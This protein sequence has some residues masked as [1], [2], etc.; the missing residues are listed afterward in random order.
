MDFLA[1]FGGIGLLFLVIGLICLMMLVRQINRSNRLL[2]E[3]NCIM[4]EVSEIRRNYNITLNGRYPYRVIGR[5]RDMYGNIH[6]FKSRN[7][8][9][10]PDALLKDNMVKVYVDGDSFKYYYM[11]IDEILP[12]VVEH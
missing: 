6:I 10:N 9:F 5:Y 11:D 12:K 1:V 8:F 4:A 7:L 2:R 3:G